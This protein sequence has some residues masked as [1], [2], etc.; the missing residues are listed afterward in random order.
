V[1]GGP[2]GLAAAT[3]AAARGRHVT[4][5]E[6]AD[7]L[8]GSVTLAARGPGRANLHRIIDFL[9]AE[10]SRL[11]VAIELGA[12]MTVERI[13]ELAPAAVIVATGAIPGA[14]LLPLV[15]PASGATPPG[16]PASG[17]GGELP[18]VTTI[19]AVLAGTAIIGP[20]VA[21]VDEI[22]GHGAASAAELLLEQGHE[23][24]MVTEDLFVGR[25]LVGTHDLTSWLQ[26][27][28]P[29]GLRCSPR[30][31]VLAIA[32][33]GLRVRDVFAPGE[34]LI[35][36]DAVVL[37]AYELPDQALYLALKG[38]VPALHRAG[39]CMAPRRI[40]QAMLEGWRAGS[41]V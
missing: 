11:G 28:L 5:Y 7:H 9:A 3:R 10:S 32:P 8:G 1:G 31:A 34:R 38:R 33:A 39:D 41:L 36:A 29:M 17:G 21:I 25:E 6:R 14:G 24:E 30:T 27:T 23:V 2:A 4:L 20:R 35:P 13:R 40:S 26:R 22:G 37:G 15:P 12:E 18:H 19:R 16:P